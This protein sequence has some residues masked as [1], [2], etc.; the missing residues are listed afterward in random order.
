MGYRPLS[1]LCRCGRAPSRIDEV[2]L[3]DDHELVIHWWCEACQRVV[4]AT[5]PLTECW[6]DCPDAG[7]AG[8]PRYPVVQSADCGFDGDF[9]KDLGISSLDEA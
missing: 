1:L 8:P 5:R 3:S 7:S 4:Y 6:R 2:G 9:L